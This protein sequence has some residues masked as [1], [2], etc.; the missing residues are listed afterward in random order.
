[1]GRL[2]WY[3]LSEVESEFVHLDVLSEAVDKIRDTKLV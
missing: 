2:R 3:D 1:M